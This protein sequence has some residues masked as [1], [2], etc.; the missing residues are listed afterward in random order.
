M[1]N[2]FN[3]LLNEG[4]EISNGGGIENG[5]EVV[6]EDQDRNISKEEVEVAKRK[7]KKGKSAGMDG[8][9]GEMIKERPRELIDWLVRLFNVCWREGRVLQ[10]WQD[11]CVVLSWTEVIDCAWVGHFTE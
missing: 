6:S 3:D 10:E 2:V 9:Y 8:I 7:V 5:G 1:E 4:I 11:S